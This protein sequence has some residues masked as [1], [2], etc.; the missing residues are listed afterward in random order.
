MPDMSESEVIAR[1]KGTGYPILGNCQ[2][3]RGLQHASCARDG[4]AACHAPD[5]V[6]ILGL[7]TVGGFA[8]AVVRCF[9]CCATRVQFQ[10]LPHN[11]SFATHCPAGGRVRRFDFAMIDK[12]A[13]PECGVRFLYL[14]EGKLFVFDDR[15]DAS[16]YRVGPEAT[17]EYGRLSYHWLCASCCKT[18]TVAVDHQNRLQLVPVACSTRQQH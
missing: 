12:C 18:I 7:L 10:F 16:A 17:S 15:G 3:D 9:G 14:R 13:N 2:Y 8:C 11:A 1:L 5:R 6:R 4:V